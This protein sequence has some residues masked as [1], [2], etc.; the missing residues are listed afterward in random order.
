M[1]ADAAPPSEALKEEI[2]TLLGE[3]RIMCVATVRPDGC[4]QATMVGYLNDD[5]TLYFAVAGTSQKLSNIRR[6]PRVSIAIGHDAPNR[7]RGLSMAAQVS[8]VT[9]FQEITRINAILH[10]R[11]PEQAVFAPREAS[12]VVLKATP[13]LVSIIDLAKGPGHPRLVVLESET[14]VR[15]AEAGEPQPGAGPPAELG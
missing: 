14:V 4:P 10:A 11:Y 8:E 13:T 1:P 15:P 6:D 9:D 5:L 7:I 2:L 3:N 12:A